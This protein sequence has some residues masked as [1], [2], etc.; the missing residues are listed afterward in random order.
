ML[1]CTFQTPVARLPLL[2][3]TD[4]LSATPSGLCVLTL[5]AQSPVVPESTVIPT[6]EACTAQWLLYPQET[7]TQ[8]AAPIPRSQLFSIP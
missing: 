2:G 1:C 4:S 3:H 6:E 8:L 7:R 5:H